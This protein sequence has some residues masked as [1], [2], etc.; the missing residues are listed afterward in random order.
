MNTIKP[1]N[2]PNQMNLNNLQQTQ[3][4]QQLKNQI[5]TK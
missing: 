5:F 1:L 3:Q 4:Q 2:N